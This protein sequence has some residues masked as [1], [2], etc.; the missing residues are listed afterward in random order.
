MGLGAFAC[1]VGATK[2]HL[3]G[4]G[5]FAKFDGWQTA[6]FDTK[7]KL[8]GWAMGFGAFAC[9]VRGPKMHLEGLEFL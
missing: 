6:G 2:K 7:K 1:G 3:E 5:G 9:G 8:L 4:L